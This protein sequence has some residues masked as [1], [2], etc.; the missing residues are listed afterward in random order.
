MHFVLPSGQK[1]TV[2]YRADSR[3]ARDYLL[4][5]PSGRRL[6]SRVD[7]RHVVRAILDQ[8][9]E[10]ACTGFA[11]V[12]AA[13]MLFGECRGG[14]TK[15]PDLSERW[16][17]HHAR[18]L[19]PWEGENYHGSTLRAALDAW[20]RK[21]ICTDEDW[22]YHP[23]DKDESDPGFDLVGHERAS[24]P[25]SGAAMSAAQFRLGAY[26]RLTSLEE[27]RAALV[28]NKVAL[29][30]AHIHDGWRSPNNGVIAYPTRNYLGGHAFAVVG[31][32]EAEAFFW[33]ANSW[34]NTWGD[35]GFARLSY[36]DLR[37]NLMDAWAPFVH[38]VP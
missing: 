28:D 26:Y 34:G 38:C 2:G 5:A 36:E 14:P 25:S 27:I 1:I 22:P 11:V 24:G 20:H 30:G 17:Y 15:A 4:K 37:V 8:H 12:T 21:G 16:A 32:D 10:G 31:Y 6:P 33:V 18:R 9:S 29:I 7:N 35:K 19:D 3:D 23:Y 13:E